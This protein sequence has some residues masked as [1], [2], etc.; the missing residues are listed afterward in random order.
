M[1]V[2]PA[3]SFWMGTRESHPDLPHKPPGAKPLRPHDVL[4]ARA[5]PAWRHADERPRRSVTLTA[6]FALD[7]QEVTNGQYTRFLRQVRAGGD[8]PWRHPDQPAGKDHTP[9]YWK[10]YNPLLADATYA[11]T[12]PFTRDTFKAPNKPVV[13]VD[14]FDAHAYCR[15]AGKA[16][17]TE[18]QWEKACRGTDGRRWPWGN[19]WRWGLCNTGGEKAGAD[20]RI[21]G[22]LKDGYIYPAPAGSFPKGR[23]AY[24]CD[25]MAGNVAEW[26]ADWY[27]AGY[28]AAAPA[29]DPRGP[30]R[31]THRVIRGGNS[32]N[33]PSQ[34][35]CAARNHFEPE[36]RAFNLGFR[37]ARGM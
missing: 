21:K 13:G 37:C 19:R 18:A 22:K 33:S 29:K 16:L 1:M 20:I 27:A 17:P 15:W 10:D 3:G 9:R 31:G 11:R 7:R 34:V 26:V 25:D 4:L 8:G 32:Q 35:R 30:A 28:Y 12:A 24:G 6:S 14:W 2:V 23:S 36:Y 5:E